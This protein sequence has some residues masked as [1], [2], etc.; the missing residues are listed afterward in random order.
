MAK[1]SI[2]A[3]TGD[4]VTT[5]WTVNFTGGYMDESHVTC[6]VNG[7]VDGSQQPVYRPITFISPGLIEV[8]GGAAGVGEEVLFRRTTPIVS[9]INDFEGGAQF[10][11]ANVDLSFQQILF[12]AQEA[13]DNLADQVDIELTLAQ[14][15]ALRNE[16][17]GFKNEADTAQEA[18]ETA[19]GLSENARDTSIAQA[20]VAT[21]QATNAANS[22]AAAAASE[23]DAGNHQTGAETARTGAETARA[24]AETART[25]AETARTGAETAATNA[26]NSASAAATS[27]A[28]A[29]TS[30]TNAANSAVSAAQSAT[31]AATSLSALDQTNM[32]ITG[33]SITGITDL[34]VAD[35]GTGASTAEDARTN[36]GMA[37]VSEAEAAAGV[38]TT[39]RSWTAERVRT[40]ARATG[41]T[42]DLIIN[43]A[44][45][46]AQRGPSA[47]GVTTAGFH[48]LDRF[49]LNLASIGE[50][51]VSQDTDAPEGFA[52]S[53][54]LQCTTADA[55]P[56]AG[57]FIFLQQVFEGQDVQHLKK[58]SA[59]AESVSVGFWVKSNKTGD[60]QVNLHDHDNSRHIGS[61]VTINAAGTWEYKTVTFAGDVSGILDND[62]NGS[63]GLEWWFDRGSSWAS[64]SAPTSWQT[65]T[66]ANRG[67]GATLALADST[68]N[69]INIT[70]VQLV[71][72]DTIPEFKHQLYGDVLRQCERYLQ[73]IGGVSPAQ[74][75]I[76]AFAVWTFDSAYSGITFSTMRAAPDAQL[77]GTLSSC[78]LY[79]APTAVSL[80]NFTVQAVSK[81]SA[82]IIVKWSG[83]FVA[84][85][86]AWLRLGAG[87]FLLLS[88][89]I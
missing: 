18:A 73:K 44:M 89:E 49:Y 88:S 57:D 81:S 20:G 7:E 36:L 16:A 2:I 9:P 22:A 12:G 51:T 24:G 33:G 30:E 3:L 58:G 86:A 76:G 61:A 11:A 31:D 13:A 74:T 50:W 27:E 32:N 41:E 70:G 17:E 47:T 77:V 21:T 75:S 66:G 62:A 38:G 64:G 72:G 67:A 78:S 14:V 83:S 5:Q 85:E 15:T 42:T 79:S 10:S 28:N 63:L 55:A 69:Y 8:G 65:A 82:E 53:L 34:A 37:T 4:G 87:V 6:Q 59:N 43:G 1:N 29:G 71:A 19:Q 48:C 40:A 23:V 68:S 35:G 39:V 52:H 56:G 60:I 46:V 80:T 84:G 25:G 26:G 45:Q 54:K